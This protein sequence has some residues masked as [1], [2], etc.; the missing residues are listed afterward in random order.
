MPLPASALIYLHGRGRADGCAT[1]NV[2]YVYKIVIIRMVLGLVLTGVPPL[3][4]AHRSIF[5]SQKD[6]AGA[7]ASPCARRTVQ[8]RPEAEM[9]W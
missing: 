5:P 6:L 9:S 4:V 8:K 1:R 7:S 3:S 2:R